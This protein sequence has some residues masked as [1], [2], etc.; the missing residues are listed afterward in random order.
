MIEVAETS[1]GPDPR[2][3]FLAGDQVAVMLQQNL[4]NLERLFL[5]LDQAS[6]LAELSGVEIDLEVSKPNH[7]LA[8]LHPNL[9]REVV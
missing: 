7:P 4:Q 3:Q 5:E 9:R 8:V 6:R 1:L 2:L